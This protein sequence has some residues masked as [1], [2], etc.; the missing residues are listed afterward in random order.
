MYGHH[1]DI[2]PA[3]ILVKPDETVISGRI[4]RN[5]RF[6][7]KKTIYY[8]MVYKG[9]ER[10]SLTYNTTIDSTWKLGALNVIRFIGDE[11]V[12]DFFK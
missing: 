6:W 1:W 7:P 5:I 8:T 2:Y 11:M 4:R 3:K 10:V 12:K 9:D